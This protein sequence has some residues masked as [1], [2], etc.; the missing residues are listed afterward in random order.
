MEKIIDNL[1]TGFSISDILDI[2]IVAFIL[3][4]LLC[5]IEDSRAGQLV[6]GI[7]IL[8]LLFVLSDFLNLYTLHWLLKST[9]TVGVIALVVVFQPELRRAL[10]Y[11]G[12]S[13]FVNP[14]FRHMDGEEI[15]HIA[16]EFAT[17]VGELAATKTGAL[18]I[19]EKETPLTDIIET[20]TIIDS[21]VSSQLIGNMF[22]EG[23]PLHDGAVIVRG[24]KLYAAGCVLPLTQDKALN[25]ALGTRHRAGIGVT[26][27]SDALAIIV[28]EE[29][30][31]V[32]IAENGNLTRFL[33]PVAI[34]SKLLNFYNGQPIDKKGFSLFG[35]KFN[36]KEGDSN[37]KK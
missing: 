13:K 19:F 33:D 23:A 1:I 3:Y 4:K 18:L 26:E 34:E 36:K 8:A 2:L 10:E 14:S 16:S 37:A 28:S 7:L 25:K 22:Y 21:K 27:N 30:G 9:F 29:T 11:V 6:K 15:K 5:F 31:I 32:S 35:I 17:A 12:R 20:G 24:E